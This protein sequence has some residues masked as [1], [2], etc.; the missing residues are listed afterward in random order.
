MN[1]DIPM[2]QRYYREEGEEEAFEKGCIEL[3]SSAYIS[4]IV[5]VK[6]KTG[7]WRMCMDF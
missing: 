6:N 3:S 1:D 4:P 7:Q 2:K 5:M